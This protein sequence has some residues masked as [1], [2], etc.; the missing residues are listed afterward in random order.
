MSILRIN[1]NIIALNS[2]RALRSISSDIA[3]SLER[4]SSGLRINRAA[5]DAAGLSISENLRAQVRGLNRA[6]QNA[7]DGISLIQTAEGALSETSAILQRVREL[8]VQ[9]SSGS[10]T[11]N[12]RISIQNEVDQLIDEIDRIAQT[13]EFNSKK[14]LNGTFGAL[15][16]SDDPSQIRAAVVGNVG[17]GGNFTIQLNTIDAGQLQVQ[18]TDVF[19][20]ISSADAVGE[21]NYLDTITLDATFTRTAGNSY[22]NTGIVQISPTPDSGGATAVTN[23][24]A[25]LYIIS[26]VDAGTSA[27]SVNNLIQA[28]EL[29]GGIDS[30][31]FSFVDQQGGV[32]TTTTI[33]TSG[34][35][36]AGLMTSIALAATVASPGTVT[37]TARADGSFSISGN[38][39]NIGSAMKLSFNDVDS[40]GSKL[41][42][43]VH[44]GLTNQ[45]HSLANGTI[46]NL[47]GTVTFNING[48]RV[49]QIGNAATT[50]TFDVRFDNV[51]TR[52]L[53]S[54]A[55]TPPA[56][57]SLGG[58]GLVNDVIAYANAAGSVAS[59]NSPL[60]FQLTA[61]ISAV[62]GNIVGRLINANGIT[63]QDSLTVNFSMTGG[64]AAS[65]TILM[66]PTESVASL[67]DRV[68]VAFSNHS[69][70]TSLLGI[71][72]NGTVGINAGR[73][74]ITDA[75][76]N[77]IVDFSSITFTDADNSGSQFFISM[78]TGT[79][80]SL[81]SNF[82]YSAANYTV[83]NA[84]GT[85]Y[86]G[87]VRGG[88]RLYS[89]GNAA[90][91]GFFGRLDVTTVSL[92]NVGVVD[93]LYFNRL[94]VRAKEDV[95]GTSYSTDGNQFQEF[96]NV[97][98]VSTP[99]SNGTIYLSAITDRTYA[100]YTFNN[101]A[102]SSIASAGGTRQQSIQA[103][104]NGGRITDGSGGNVFSV[105]ATVNYSGNL[106]PALKGIE[107]GFSGFLTQGETATFNTST[108]NVLTGD[109]QNT[110][111]SINRFQD[112]GV[113][114]GRSNL[115]FTVYVKGYGSSTINITSNDTLED[116]AGKISLAIFDGNRASDL[117]IESTIDF[118]QPPDIVHVNTV[119]LAKGTISITTPIPGLDLVFSGDESFLNAMSLI[120]IQKAEAPIYS[121]A[122]YNIET[123]QLIGTQK[124]NSGK[125]QGLL[126][127]LD[128][129]LDISGGMKLDPDPPVN[130][131]NL[132]TSNSPYWLAAERPELSLAVSAKR[133]FLHVAPRDFILQIGA[134]QGQTI[135]TYI[136]DLRAE[137]LGVKNLLVVDTKNAQESIT[138]VDQA[139]SRVSAERGRL[140]AIQNRLE[141]TI[142]NLDVA[143]E[144]LVSSESRIRDVDVAAETLTSTRNQIR[145]QAAIAAL[146]Q[147]NQLPQAVLQL[148]R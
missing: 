45:F 53:V 103:A 146:A 22:G 110:L 102:Y 47:G 5:D 128:I 108:N 136:G 86:N 88:G 96:Q 120:E 114:N 137:A 107:I 105:G 58:T 74:F 82:L 69:G 148:L 85:T 104:I 112:F 133:L 67:A 79:T 91:G 100:L 65:I 80:T 41:L 124:I 125:I 131:M 12:D 7:L 27:V 121:V 34:Q 83:T 109:Q 1:Q 130:N 75:V 54:V 98:Q 48:G 9:A 40:S 63:S 95:I 71:A 30:V 50:G 28:Y 37:F 11:S 64:I 99:S 115:Q 145:L 42:L 129:F 25:T 117:N 10:L 138:I 94:T 36:L 13:T 68:S 78:V 97:R 113:F 141:I 2:N 119:G 51:G 3:K 72:W 143:A 87:S 18:K 55:F 59:D 126:G 32:H 66:D 19:A 61:M 84:A 60:R 31:T 140:G 24:A 70:L 101:Q 77:P 57:S 14:L 17:K 21:V 116:L 29:T 93:A 44:G 92:T 127:G 73:L 142:R 62:G 132:T 56:G 122:A 111:A 90:A 106:I 35:T 23:G 135:S 16:S 15:I 81:V 33:I 8:A 46:T 4:L 52:D 38:G 26:L 139:I 89:V 6:S 43:S 147:A 118:F 144:N 76:L 123:N 134:N 49:R 39:V 20:T